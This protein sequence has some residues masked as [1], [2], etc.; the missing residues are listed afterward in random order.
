MIIS[1]NFSISYILENRRNINSKFTLA[2][3]SN[4]NFRR[5]KKLID[6]LKKFKKIYFIS[7]SKSLNSKFLKLLIE[8]KKIKVKIKYFEENLKNLYPNEDVLDI[9]CK[10]IDL[11]FKK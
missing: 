11:F 9:D 8:L 7:D 6:Y 4:Q 10:E 2:N 5:T 3:L 1:S